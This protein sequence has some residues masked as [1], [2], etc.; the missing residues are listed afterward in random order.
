MQLLPNMSNTE[1]V[2]RL[3]EGD[4][5][6][7]TELHNACF[8]MVYLQAMKILNNEGDAEEVT[9]DVFITV[10]RFIDRLQDPEALRS[11]I[12]G[13]AVRLSLKK[14]QKRSASRELATEEEAM[15]DYLETGG[16]G[17][18]PEEL[19]CDREESAALGELVEQLPE[20][21]RT[22][23]MMFYYDNCAV[24]EIAQAMSCA[25]GTVKSRLNYARKNLEKLIL[26][27]G[28]TGAVRLRAV[29]PAMLFMA[30]FLQEQGLELDPAVIQRS[31]EH[32]RGALGLAAAGAAAAGAGTA[33]AGSGSAAGAAAAEGAAAAGSTAAAGGAAAGGAAAGGLGAK[34]AALVVAGAVAVGGGG[35][36]LTHLPQ[37]PDEPA[38]AV[39]E[40]AT[41]SP[42][43]AATASPTPT[44]APTPTP[45][46]TPAAT[47]TPTP[48]P[49]ATPT[50]TAS[51]TPSP[52][53]STTPSPTPSP[54]PTPTPTPAPTPAPT[55]TPAPVAGE[56][57]TTSYREDYA[58]GQYLQIQL[59]GTTLTATGMRVLDN[60]LYNY[61]VFGTTGT[62]VET[63]FVSGQPFTL[64]VEVDLDVLRDIEE[65]RP[66][67]FSFITLTVCQNYTPG[68]DSFGGV[69]FQNARIVA[70]VPDG[71]GGGIIMVR[72]GT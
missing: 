41:P 16:G 56:Y 40:S 27:Q 39:V 63:P 32:V 23:V 70:M 15:F 26:R 18:S 67:S 64:S 11:W 55:P 37:G 5:D 20:E 29:S 36:A 68:D 49:T 31:L 53:P 22:T 3:R 57:Y 48:A 52:T 58:D 24:K 12:G 35:Y 7:F 59:N 66:D 61:V 65:N 51:P 71:S 17:P 33:A 4:N 60:S 42:T 72:S 46:A 69:S 38:V 43:P 9:Q 21:Q 1:V 50:P 47:P 10:F 6:T 30:F 44:A 14:R 54:T 62:R 28:E 2:R 8:R 25:E 13:I 19:L 45:A 34:V